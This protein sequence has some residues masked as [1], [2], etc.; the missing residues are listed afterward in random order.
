MAD[1]PNYWDYL[2]LETLLS[3][4]DGMG[5]GPLIPD[6]LHFIIT[7]Q[8]FELW[9]KLALAELRL[10]RD[11]LSAP[12]VPEERIPYVVHHLRRVNAVLLLAANT[13]EVMET[14]TPQDFLSF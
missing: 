12:A 8:V 7:H 11:H 6:E 14:L 4:Q 10:A 13:F 9:L 5:D 2:G 1:L 3:L